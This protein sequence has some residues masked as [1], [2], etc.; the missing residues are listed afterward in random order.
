MLISLALQRGC[1]SAA[2][3]NTRDGHIAHATH[4]IYAL[5]RIEVRRYNKL[6]KPEWTPPNAVFGPVWGM[7]Y[8]G[9]GVASWLVFKQGGW[10]AQV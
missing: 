8:A 5:S 4:A 7:L 9:M 3:T 10:A 6:R 2:I 1:A